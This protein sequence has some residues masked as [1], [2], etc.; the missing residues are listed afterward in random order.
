MNRTIAIQILQLPETIPLTTEA[1][2]AAQRTLSQRCHPD[3]PG[4]DM[5]QFH[6]VRQAAAFLIREIETVDP[7]EDIFKDIARRA[8]E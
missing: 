1:V 4:G 8:K 5:E 6:R 7:F 3:K 2:R